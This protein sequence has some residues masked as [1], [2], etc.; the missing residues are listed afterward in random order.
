MLQLH[1]WK[2]RKE[3]WFWGKE[4]SNHI[5]EK[6]RCSAWTGEGRWQWRRWWR[7]WSVLMTMIDDWRWWWWRERW[8]TCSIYVI[9][10]S[11]IQAEKK[12]LGE[13]RAWCP[14]GVVNRIKKAADLTSKMHERLRAPRR[15]HAWRPGRS[16]GVVPGRCSRPGWNKHGVILY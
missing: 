4:K 16:V 9:R 15:R 1:T 3:K 11:A 12:N 7:C 2:K 5:K 6:D 13:A 10:P 8:L 14:R